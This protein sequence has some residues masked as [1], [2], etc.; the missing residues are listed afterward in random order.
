MAISE[1]LRR[2][3]TYVGHD[4]VLVPSVAV[5]PRDDTG[6][7]LLVR[8]TDTGQW[9]TI[10]G[11]VEVDE[12]P[13]D[14]ARREAREEAGIQVDLGEILDV[15]GGPGFRIRYPN[16]DETAYVSTVYSATVVNGTPAPDGDETTDVKWF[17]PT[18]LAGLDLRPFARRTFT[19]LGLL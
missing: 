6:R 1:Y 12:P 10:G 9:M 15:V 19:R 3:R 14:A 8:D 2:I 16:G 18:E 7:I 11:A 5:L 4:L 17:T 13:E